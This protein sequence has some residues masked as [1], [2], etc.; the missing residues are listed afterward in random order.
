[1]L[2]TELKPKLIELFEYM[3]ATRASLLATVRDMNTT[4]AEMKPRDG[5]WS[6]SEILAHLAIVESRVLKMM[7]SG[8]EAARKEGIGPDTSDRRIVGSLSDWGVVEATQKLK[9][10]TTIVPERPEPI[11]KSVASLEESRKAIKNIL[12]ENLDI[13]LHSIKRPHPV[14]RELDMYQWALFA[15]EHEERHRRQIERT[16]SEVTELCAESAPIV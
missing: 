15:A 2:M 13:D 6:A 7:G 8:I 5:S 1:M 9:A 14:L 16:L 4:F 11:D 10:P 12:I 3:D